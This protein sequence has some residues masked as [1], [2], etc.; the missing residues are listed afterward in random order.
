MTLHFFSSQKFARM[1]VHLSEAFG[2]IVHL[3]SY[4]AGLSEN[5]K[6]VSE[7]LLYQNFQLNYLDGWMDW[8]G[9]W[10]EVKIILVVGSTEEFGW[11]HSKKL[12][13]ELTN[14]NQ[15]IKKMGLVR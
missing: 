2:M 6:Y 13:R 12:A 8:N 14:I 4:S 3:T 9:H 10:R 1:C 11:F 7:W 5:L 15:T